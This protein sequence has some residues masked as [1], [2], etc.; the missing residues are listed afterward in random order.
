MQAMLLPV[1]FLT[2]THYYTGMDYKGVLNSMDH[3][4][5]RLLFSESHYMEKEMEN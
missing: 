3:T 2:S 5:A 1:T 4:S